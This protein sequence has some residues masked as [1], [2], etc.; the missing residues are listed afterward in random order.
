MNQWLAAMVLAA[1]CGWAGAAAAE[2]RQAEAAQPAATAAA[3]APGTPD[4]EFHR[5]ARAAI[6]D[7]LAERKFADLNTDPGTS[8]R[9]LLTWLNSLLQGIASWIGKL[10]GWL[11]WTLVAWMVL[12]LLAILGHLIYTLVT[13]LG[14][15]SGAS[16]RAGPGGEHPAQLLGLLPLDFDAM[17]AEARRLL[18]AGD[19][20]AATKHFYVAAILWLDRQGCI[21]F[22]LSKTNRDYIEELRTRAGLQAGFRWLTGCF[23]P[24]VYGGL[25]ATKSTTQDVVNKVED[26]LHESAGGVAS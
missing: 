15:I 3:Q 1:A 26:L 8:G 2:E 9:W 17:Y 12:T 25:S 16:R 21:A 20:L 6:R 10:P 13:T 18:A 7:V 5:R 22:R 24:I 23:E 14:G 19:W 4:A 11:V